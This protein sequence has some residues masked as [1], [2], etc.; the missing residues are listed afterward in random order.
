MARFAEYGKGVSEEVTNLSTHLQEARARAEAVALGVEIESSPSAAASDEDTS[1]RTGL[2]GEPKPIF[3]ATLAVRQQS[4][5]IRFKS[6]SEML[7]TFGMQK[8]GKEYRTDFWRH[9]LL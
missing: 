8:G 6:G 4:Q 1:F 5:T 3:L 9:D 2:T 7:E